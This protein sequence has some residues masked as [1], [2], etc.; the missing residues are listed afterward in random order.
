M[1][2]WMATKK[3]WLKSKRVFGVWIYVCLEFECLS[4]LIINEPESIL[5][6]ALH[7]CVVTF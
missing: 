7:L 3:V 1:S 6:L 5:V 2:Y 4:D